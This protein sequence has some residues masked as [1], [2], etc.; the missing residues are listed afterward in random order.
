MFPRIAL[1]IRVR[2]QLGRHINIR[3]QKHLFVRCEDEK[4]AKLSILYDH[5]A[6]L[7]YNIIFNY[8]LKWHFY[9]II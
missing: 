8:I 4:H 3:E 1:S 9:F 2:F 6:P 5:Q 7:L